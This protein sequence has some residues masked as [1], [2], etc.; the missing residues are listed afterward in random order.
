MKLYSVRVLYTKLSPPSLWDWIP[1]IREDTLM[2]KLQRSG[3]T[4]VEEDE[5]GNKYA[6]LFKDVL[7]VATPV[8]EAKTTDKEVRR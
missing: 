3:V 4:K 8:G 5:Y 7:V 2:K 6:W 1:R